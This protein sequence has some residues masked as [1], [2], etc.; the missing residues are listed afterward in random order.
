MQLREE[1]L[2]ARK[3]RVETGQVQVGKEVVSQQRTLYVP[4]TREEVTIERHPVD[5]RPVERP[6]DDHQPSI[7]VPVHEERVDLDKRAVVYEEVGVEQAR[8]AR[9]P[10]G[11]GHRSP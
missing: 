5:R 9:D 1:E 10:A 8:G 2:V 7:S 3:Q 11:H 6:I 4:V